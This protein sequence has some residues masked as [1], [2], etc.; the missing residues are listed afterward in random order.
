MEKATNNEA[1]FKNAESPFTEV[2]SI[3][4]ST[5]MSSGKQRLDE[6]DIK[7]IDKHL[8]NMFVSIL[9]GLQGVGALMIITSAMDEPMNKNSIHIGEFVAVISNLLETIGLFCADI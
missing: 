7:I 4:R 5:F 2:Y 9:R 8:S 6:N 3:L 1:K